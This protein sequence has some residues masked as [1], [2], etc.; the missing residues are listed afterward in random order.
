MKVNIKSKFDGRE[1]KRNRKYCTSPIGH[2]KFTRQIRKAV[3]NK[4][5]TAIR[6]GREPEPKYPKQTEYYD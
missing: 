6:S 5:K 3:R 1:N 4:A 2:A